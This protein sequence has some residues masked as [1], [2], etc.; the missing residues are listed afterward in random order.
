[1]RPRVCV[2][3]IGTPYRR[4]ALCFPADASGSLGPG[5]EIGLRRNVEQHPHRRGRKEHR[6]SAKADERHRKPGRRQN[7]K[8]H[9]PRSRG[10]SSAI[11]AVI[12]IA[13]YRPKSSGACRAILMPRSM[14]SRKRPTMNRVPISPYSSPTIEKTKSPYDSGRKRSR[15][16]LFA[17]PEPE[18]A[19]VSEPDHRLPE[20]V[21]RPSRRRSR[22][23]NSMMR[24]MR[25]S[26]LSM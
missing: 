8:G 22:R 12:P 23:C 20:L 5:V 1:M 17:R 6:R 2:D 21:V 13:R 10:R 11:A 19:A 4:L 7:P 14:I 16:R 18:D 9:R 15:C 25:Y 3:S 24:R 26:A